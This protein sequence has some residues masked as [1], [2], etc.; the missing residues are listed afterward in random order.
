VSVAVARFTQRRARDAARLLAASALACVAFGAAPRFALAQDIAPSI[1]P[2]AAPMPP[3]VPPAPGPPA[4]PPLP[5]L[6][7]PPTAPGTTS[8]GAP[9]TR[10][11]SWTATRRP[12]FGDLHVHTALSFDA[13]SLGVRGM[14]A[15]A[16][17]FAKGE[18]M[19]LQPYTASGSPRRRVKLER[20][21]DFAAVT[22]HAELLGEL[23][24]CQTPNSSGY[25][26]LICRLQRRWPLMAYYFVNSRMLSVTDPQR[27][28]FCGEKGELCRQAAAGPWETI[29]TA[30]EAAYD[31]TAAC[32]FTSF[33]AYEWSGGP[34]G[35]MTHRNVLFADEKAPELPVSFID[36]PTG[37][38][39]WDALERECAKTGCR[40]LT[41]PH[42]SNLSNGVLFGA[43][44]TSAADAKRRAELEPILEV[45]QHK[46]DSECRAGAADE[47][48]SFEKLPFSRME[49]QPFE[50][51]WTQP[52]GTSFAREILAAG[53]EYEARLGVNPYRLGF[54]S[55][56]DSHLATPGLV[57]EKTYP[58]HGAGGDTTR[59]EIPVV[60]DSLFFNPGGLAGVWAEENTRESIWAAIQRREV[61]ST[62][63]P[64]IVVRFFGGFGYADGLCES[65]RFAE[66]GYAGGVAM[67][68]ELA[69]V[70]GRKPVFAVTALQDAGT[71]ASPGTPLERVQIV[72]LW[73]DGSEVKEKVVDVAVS[74]HGIAELDTATCEPVK[75]G[76]A[77]LCGQ[78]TDDEWDP[79]KSTVYYARVL[80]APSCRWTGHLCA[81]VKV[82]CSNE[83]AIPEGFE[84]CCTDSI[85]KVQHER[86]LTSPIW[87]H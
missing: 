59:V 13:N 22:D 33:V 43:E 32:S 62:S 47:Y 42:N 24:L 64:R 39:L 6:A 54:I 38:L 46:G 17:R 40:F 10:C 14:P 35:N 12:L 66:D 23:Y 34:G 81:K 57:D 60:A 11:A 41:I 67:G 87:I 70:A 58:G 19:G 78:W 53:L 45:M 36:A 61:F 84:F 37:E 20:P 8:P 5:E 3:S 7:P 18:E 55:A 73:L 56:T 51:R 71:E 72:K 16:Y 4:P 76:S 30:A 50:F 63:G 83:D 68:G 77:S 9:H 49:E 75:K 69:G 25:D 27:Y 21:L 74:P 26:S 44:I 52:E 15:D 82:D 28:G 65:E 85:P 2:P 86:A 1:L 79:A 80:E 48:C 31:R 29:R